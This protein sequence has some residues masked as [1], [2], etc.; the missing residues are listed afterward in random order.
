MFKILWSCKKNP[1]PLFWS[2]PPGLRLIKTFFRP[3]QV[4][5]NTLNFWWLVE[6]NAEKLGNFRCF[7][8]RS[9][10]S[11]RSIWCW[12]EREEWM[13]GF[14]GWELLVCF[15]ELVLHLIESKLT[16]GYQFPGLLFEGQKTR[17]KKQYSSCICGLFNQPWI[18]NKQV[19]QVSMIVARKEHVILGYCDIG[20]RTYW[21]NWPPN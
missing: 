6:S 14:E 5:T 17:K 11:T 4:R 8:Y 20:K 13:F 2:C 19:K 9:G 7:L 10:S 12:D 3:N 1:P 21:S 16:N 18:H 15:L